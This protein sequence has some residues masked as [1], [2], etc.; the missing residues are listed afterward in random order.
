MTNFGDPYI[1]VEDADYKQNREL[2]LK[3]YFEKTPLDV[4]YAE[5]TLQYI[6]TIWGRTVHL[7]TMMDNKKV[8]FTYDGRNNTKRAIN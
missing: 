2:Y 4:G 5:K 6:Y 3:H 1:M 8:L 7:E